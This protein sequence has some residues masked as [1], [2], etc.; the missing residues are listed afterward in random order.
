M[1]DAPGVDVEALEA[2]LRAELPGLL[3][4]PLSVELLTGGRSNLTYLLSDGTGRWVLR[5]PPL[6][7]V[8]E[9]AHDMGREHRLLSALHPTNVPVPRPLV[10]AGR[11]VIGAPFYVMEF[12]DGAVLS[13]RDQ[14]AA[15]DASGA[16][17]LAD[18][19]ID[20]LARLHRLDPDAVGLGDLGRPA[21][22]LER[23]LRRWARQLDASRSR[24]LP[25]LDR[26]HERLSARLPE[27]QGSG[28]VHGDYRLDNAIVDPRTR[29]VTAVLD[30]EMATLGDPLTDLGSAIM[31]WDG[32]RG[33]NGPV[34]ALPGD[35]AAFPDGGHLVAEYGRITG[36]DLSE[37]P[38]YCGFAYYKMAAIFEGIHYRS[39][40]GMTVGEGFDRI[41]PLV[42]P[43]TERGHAALSGGLHG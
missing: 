14:L 33:L 9:T 34:A 35:L 12:A 13:T 23:Q 27:R 30:W 21:G 24:D 36:T 18:G 15:F 17:A 2:F 6:G 8:L 26:L 16:T 22:Y 29:T 39:L 37:M 25:E 40:Q 38:W 4:G 31:W 43:L 28:I 41:G 5:R 32:M 7:H 3:T 10:L 19:L 11:D 42:L 20:V 1:A